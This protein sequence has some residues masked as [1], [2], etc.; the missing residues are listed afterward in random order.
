MNRATQEHLRK[1]YGE[2]KAQMVCMPIFN[3]DVKNAQPPLDKPLANG[4]PVALYAGGV[5][6]WQNIPLMQQAMAA[7]PDAFVYKMFLPDPDA[8]AALLGTS[9][10]R[11]IWCWTA[12]PPPSWWRNTR[13][14]TTALC[15]GTTSR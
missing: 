6:A 5:Q 7:H 4:L 11:P 3:E 14:P 13:P 9:P 2:L 1:R 12:R 15:C 8:F 10:S